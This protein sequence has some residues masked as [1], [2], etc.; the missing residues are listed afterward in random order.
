MFLLEISCPKSSPGIKYEV[1]HV[2]C[3]VAVDV[4][5]T[6]DTKRVHL[7]NLYRMVQYC[8][9]K[10]DC[11]RAQQLEYFGERFNKQLCRSF[12]G[13]VCDVCNSSVSTVVC[14]YESRLNTCVL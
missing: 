6:M 11:R 13:A 1:C 12:P 14:L 5:A 10:T 8:E 3:L 7:D 4:G 2:Y 9:N